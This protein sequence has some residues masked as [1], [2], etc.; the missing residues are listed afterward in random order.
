MQAAHEAVSNVLTAR[1]KAKA[2]AIF[3]AVEQCVVN[4]Q[5]INDLLIKRKPPTTVRLF[6]E[7]K[8]WELVE[9]QAASLAAKRINLNLSMQNEMR[10][11]IQ[12]LENDLMVTRQRN[13]ALEEQSISLQLTLEAEAAKIHR[14]VEDKL[15]K[16]EL[17]D[18]LRKLNSFDMDIMNKKIFAT[19]KKNPAPMPVDGK[20]V[21][22]GGLKY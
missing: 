6:D 18:E 11:H 8:V 2:D 19:P 20:V 13:M 22:Q 12:R 4:A 10:A 3:E 16:A 21:G 1:D 14:L 5:V 15:S 7:S 9:K 17:E